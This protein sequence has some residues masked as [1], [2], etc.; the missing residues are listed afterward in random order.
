MDLQSGN[1][2]RN[3]SL[4]PFVQRGLPTS[5]QETKYIIR[6]YISVINPQLPLLDSS[7]K[8]MLVDME[9][10]RSHGGHSKH[11]MVDNL[12]AHK[13]ADILMDSIYKFSIRNG[14]VLLSTSSPPVKLGSRCGLNFQLGSSKVA[15]GVRRTSHVAMTKG[16]T[17]GTG[18]PAS[19]DIITSAWLDVDVSTNP[20]TDTPSTPEPPRSIWLARAQ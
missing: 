20:M 12:L 2:F 11:E 7:L 13:M 15:L 16:I 3:I 18:R 5:K 1:L 14:D 6:N 8:E 9:E 19:L 4:G 17:M 10:V